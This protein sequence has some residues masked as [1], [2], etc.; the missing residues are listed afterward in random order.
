LDCVIISFFTHL[1]GEEPGIM[2]IHEYIDSKIFPKIGNTKF[3]G[4]QSMLENHL[5]RC[6]QLTLS[7]RLAKTTM[8]DRGPQYDMED[9]K[10]AFIACCNRLTFK[11]DEYDYRDHISLQLDEL[12]RFTPQYFAP[13]THEEYEE[14]LLLLG[15][16]VNRQHARSDEPWEPLIMAIVASALTYLVNHSDDFDT[17]IHGLEKYIRRESIDKLVVLMDGFFV[18]MGSD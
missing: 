14:V 2:S 15:L 4:H 7:E 10:Q 17:D 13:K 8:T 6:I 12:I 5:Q 1:S 18:K 11:L 3:N 16:M 9:L